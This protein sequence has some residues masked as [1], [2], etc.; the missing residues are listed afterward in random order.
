M[1][2]HCSISLSLG[3][4]ATMCATGCIQRAPSIRPPSFSAGR[5]SSAAFESLDANK[6]NLLDDKELVKAPGLNAAAARVDANKDGRISAEELEARIG[7]YQKAGLGLRNES[8][9]FTWN[10][11]PLSDA[12]V[13]FTPEPFF[14]DSIQPGEGTT[15][16]DGSTSVKISGNA[17]PGLTCGMYQVSVSRKDGAGKELLPAKYNTRTTLGYEFQ[18]D[19]SSEKDRTFAL[20]AR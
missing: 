1:F 18:P 8:Y 12:Q 2:T 20:T 10:G 3:A 13:T 15:N 4:I 6:D 19:E 9:F 16:K 14:A 11:A 7:D 5:I 17:I